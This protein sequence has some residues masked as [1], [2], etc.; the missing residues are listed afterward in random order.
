M[1]GVGS[2]ELPPELGGG[3]GSEVPRCPLPAPKSVSYSSQ[4][5]GGEVECSRSNGARP[6]GLGAV[7]CLAA[8]QSPGAETGEAVRAWRRACEHH[9]LL[10]SPLP[11]PPPLLAACPALRS[12]GGGRVRP[13]VAAV[14]WSHGQPRCAGLRAGEGGAT[15]Q[16]AEGPVTATLPSPRTAQPGAASTLGAGERCSREEGEPWAGEALF[17]LQPPPDWRCPPQGQVPR[18][19]TCPHLCTDLGDMLRPSLVFSLI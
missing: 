5:A 8:P 10:A 19:L 9:S 13:R 4:D 15:G 3:R 2:P 14:S 7:T 11:P 16:G 12:R 6:L 18:S 1:A 17:L